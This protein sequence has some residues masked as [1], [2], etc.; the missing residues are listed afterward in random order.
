M[1]V[2]PDTQLQIVLSL[3]DQ[4]TG[5][6]Q[7]AQGALAS[8]GQ[9]GED[10][11]AQI[12][13]ALTPAEDAVV[14]QAQ[15]AADAVAGASDEMAASVEGAA[16]DGEAAWMALTNDATLAAT[17]ATEGWVA[18]MQELQDAMAQ[19]TDAVEEDF[20]AM[21]QAAGSSASTM[22]GVFGYFRYMIAGRFME[23]AGG[24]LSGAVQAVVNAAA[25]GDQGDKIAQLTAQI[26]QQQAA[27]AQHEAS[28]QTESGTIDQINAKRAAAAAAID[29]ERVKI[30]QLSAQL[31]P[32]EAEQKANGAA[33][34]AYATAVAQLNTDW[35]QFLATVGGPL[36]AALTSQ[37]EKID[38]IV[39]SLT[40]WAAEHPKITQA[41][42]TFMGVL[43][44]LLTAL[45]ALTIALALVD[46]I[47]GITGGP[48]ILLG[49][50]IAVVSAAVVAL[51]PWIA[52]LFDEIDQKTGL[53]T[54]L[55]TAW[56]SIVTTFEKNLLPALAQLW[57]A[58][59]PLEPYLKALA[60][61][62]GV[63]LVAAIQ[64]M[65]ASLTIAVDLITDLLTVATK[66]AT[67]FINSFVGA[68]HSVTSAVQALVSAFNAVS[69]PI[70]SAIGAAIGGAGNAIGSVI[71]AFASGGI[72]SS[73]T[74]ALVGEAGPE[75]II[76]LSA[77]NGG[78]SLAGVGGAAGSIVININGGNYLDS[79]G[80]TM[81]GNALA[82]QV[83]QQLK[84]KNFN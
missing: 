6:L 81:I 32:L 73:P 51:W 61:I 18:S 83:M 56:D 25:A 1:A 49:L 75:A 10:A 41:I 28:L 65:V 59:T 76:P 34:Q 35:Q 15:A 3:I 14:A 23:Q 80:A 48:F 4:A 68:I 44:P 27:I 57:S 71:K 62:I 2:M 67:F 53:I 79:Q 72:V 36:L 42:L 43:G 5:Q 63:M 21:G 11:A 74:L 54:M 46:L 66:I 45:G 40:G 12:T 31:A 38:Q 17:N 9:A 29:A 30:Q 13:G 19:T 64:L 7:E 39:Q 8:L 26:Q 16:E 60:E 82:R 33:A 55:K 70:G 84:L 22:G 78:S 77:F 20:A 50:A 52:Q 47:A 58:F 24:A 69:G 37:I